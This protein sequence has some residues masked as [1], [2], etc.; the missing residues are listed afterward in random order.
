MIG[1]SLG[2]FVVQKYLESHVAPARSAG[3]INSTARRRRGAFTH[4]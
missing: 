4:C 3:R 2:G 1:H